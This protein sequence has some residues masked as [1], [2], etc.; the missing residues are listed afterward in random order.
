MPQVRQAQLQC[1]EALLRCVR[2]RTL[3]QDEEV[4]V[5]E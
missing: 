5:A 4:L 1:E 2:L 3:K